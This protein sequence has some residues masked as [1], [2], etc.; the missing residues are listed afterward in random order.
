MHCLMSP[1]Q[2]QTM[3]GSLRE[4][5]KLQLAQTVWIT[6]RQTSVYCTTS[7][8]PSIKSGTS[9]ATKDNTEVTHFTKENSVKLSISLL[10]AWVWVQFLYPLLLQFQGKHIQRKV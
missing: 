2:I 8:H 5:R 3:A 4:K 6:E 10:H 1:S 7:V 9:T